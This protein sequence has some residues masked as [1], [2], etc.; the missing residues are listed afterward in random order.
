ML[1]TEHPHAKLFERI[2]RPTL[3]GERPALLD[4]SIVEPFVAHT[5]GHAPIGGTFVGLRGFQGH[6]ALLRSLSGGTLRRTSIEY[7]ADD[8]WAVVSQV[9]TAT[10]GGKDLEMRVAGFW[11]FRGPGQLAEHWEA[12]ADE[13]AWDD[14]W[15]SP[16][17]TSDA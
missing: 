11:R 5:A 12:V 16:A 13:A 1:S 17:R 8:D 3:A 15:N 14:F 9:M 2:Y 6:I 7:S 10:R 4:D